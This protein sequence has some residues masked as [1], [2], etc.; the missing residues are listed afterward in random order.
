MI[1]LAEFV[2]E[3]RARAVPE[4]ATVTML[5]AGRP[6]ENVEVRVLAEDR[7]PLPD[8]V[9]GEIALR[10]NCMLTG[11]FNRPDA[12]AQAFHEGWY[13]TGD[14]GYLADG[15]VYITGRKKDLIIVG[16][17]NVY[18]QDIE[19]L[20][21]EV[22]GEFPGRG[23]WFGVFVEVAGSEVVVLVAV[24]DATDEAAR[25]RIADEIRVRV[26]KGTAV[27]LRVVE[28]VPR[29]W[30]IKTSSGKIARGANRE[31]YLKRDS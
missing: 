24:T 31:R 28:L 16:G 23:V 30:L 12:T 18:P 7:N 29:E 10:S 1:G 17:K 14:L 6:L 27:A 3:R 19:Y 8:R 26:T 9:I 25:Q 11:Y 2:G 20:A 4:G 22:P 5:S 15:E 13:L 21:K